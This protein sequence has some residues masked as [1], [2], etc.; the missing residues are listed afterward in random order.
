MS[1]SRIVQEVYHGWDSD[2]GLRWKVDELQPPVWENTNSIVTAWKSK[3]KKDTVECVL[4]IPRATV[5]V[6]NSSLS[7]YNVD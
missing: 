3:V 6:I 4:K 7:S 5:D 2:K 1:H